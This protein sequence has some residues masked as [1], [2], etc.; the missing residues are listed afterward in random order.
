[1]CASAFVEYCTI[2]PNRNQN[3]RKPYGNVRERTPT[4]VNVRKPNERC[5]VV[6]YSTVYFFQSGG[7]EIWFIDPV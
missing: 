6:R 7:H 5:G 4:Y 2:C 1:M 3:I